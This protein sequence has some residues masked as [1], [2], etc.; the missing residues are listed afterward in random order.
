MRRCAAVLSGA[1]GGGA[2]GGGSSGPPIVQRARAAVAR[3]FQAVKRY[4]RVQ[5]IAVAVGLLASD[6]GPSGLAE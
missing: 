1:A 3:P 4:V 5:L 6:A 2:G